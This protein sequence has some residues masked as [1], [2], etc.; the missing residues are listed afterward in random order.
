MSGL[1]AKMSSDSNRQGD[2]NRAFATGFVNTVYGIDIYQSNNLPNG[3]ASGLA[4]GEIGIVAGH[5]KAGCLAIRYDK[6]LT[7]SSMPKKDGEYIYQNMLTGQGA[8]NAAL[9]IKGVIT[10]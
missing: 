7:G 3:V 5:D 6:F 1:I 4:A 10:E 9:L 2:N 8:N